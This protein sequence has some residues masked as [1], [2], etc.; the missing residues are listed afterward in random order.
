MVFSTASVDGGQGQER[1]ASALTTRAAVTNA[2]ISPQVP[3]SF[4]HGLQKGLPG[5][6]LLLVRGGDL[7]E[8]VC[9][10]LGVIG[11]HLVQRKHR[12]D[13]EVEGGAVDG[14]LCVKDGTGGPLTVMLS[15]VWGQERCSRWGPLRWFGG[16][17]TVIF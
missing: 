9:R 7:Q 11:V 13:S 16:G 17:V 6:G 15:V 5:L 14:G 2:D 1:G 10:P 3:L 8:H 12:D 4:T